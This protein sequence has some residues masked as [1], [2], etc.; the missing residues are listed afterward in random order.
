MSF[1]LDHSDPC[2]RPLQCLEMSVTNYKVMRQHNAEDKNFCDTTAK[3]SLITFYFIRIFQYSHVET[4]GNSD[5]TNT[6]R[7]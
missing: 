6:V 2:L 1:L 4:E 5:R 7:I 3:T